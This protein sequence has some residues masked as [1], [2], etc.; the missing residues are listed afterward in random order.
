MIAELKQVRKVK[1]DVWRKMKK[2]YDRS[3]RLN[4]LYAS[5]AL[6]VTFRAKPASTKFRMQFT[7]G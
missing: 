7:Y 5:K 3:N 1:V 6:N 4:S 2:A